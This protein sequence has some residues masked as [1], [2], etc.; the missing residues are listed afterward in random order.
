MLYSTPLLPSYIIVPFISLLK[1]MKILCMSVNVFLHIVCKYG[2]VGLF[3][4]S[5]YPLSCGCCYCCCF[6]LVS[7]LT[8]MPQKCPFTSPVH[9]D[10]LMVVAT[11]VVSWTCVCS[12]SAD[13][14]GVAS[15]GSQ[16]VGWPSL[17][18]WYT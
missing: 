15:N 3:I 8:N 12:V 2:I 1:N 6:F 5:V 18:I 16:I 17:F 13:C 10:E 4:H 14:C 11:A 7:D 9:P